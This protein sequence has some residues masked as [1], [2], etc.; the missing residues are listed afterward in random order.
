MLLNVSLDFMNRIRINFLDNAVDVWNGDEGEPIIYHGHTLTTKITLA[1]VLRDA[2][3]L[4]AFTASPYPVILSIENHLSIEQ[5]VVMVKLLKEI[6]GDMLLTDPVPSDLS[7]LP[8]PEDLKNKV[9]I[10]AKK[11]Q[12]V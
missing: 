8:S 2:I 11:P 3:K 4:Y 7:A 12:G 1:D 10:K 6:L 9:I 5:Q